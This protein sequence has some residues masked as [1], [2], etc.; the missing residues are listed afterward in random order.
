MIG[1][2]GVDG[3]LIDLEIEGNSCCFFQFQFRCSKG[4]V[5]YTR[6][7]ISKR[8]KHITIIAFLMLLNYKGG[9]EQCLLKTPTGTHPT[10]R[11]RPFQVLVTA[12]CAYGFVFVCTEVYLLTTPTTGL[13]YYTG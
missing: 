12:P 7:K 11:S 2:G 4:Y 5:M 6:F 10:E 1:G 8:R 9:K 13:L 3:V